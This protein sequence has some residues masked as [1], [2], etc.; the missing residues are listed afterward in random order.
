MSGPEEDVPGLR[1]HV[2]GEDK[3]GSSQSEG[4]AD[5]G[6]ELILGGAHSLVGRDHEI[7][8]LEIQRVG[9]RICRQTGE[10]PVQESVQPI[11]PVRQAAL[12]HGVDLL[13][14]MVDAKGRIDQEDPLEPEVRPFPRLGE[15]FISFAT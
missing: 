9:A 4:E 7:R 12:E 11:D 15:F 10:C 13:H 6:G 3:I 5:H 1:H 2:G 14:G 8:V